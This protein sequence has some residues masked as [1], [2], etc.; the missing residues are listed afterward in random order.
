MKSG[1]R[2][3]VLDVHN[4]VLNWQE[5]QWVVLFLSHSL[6]YSE[7]K[8][9]RLQR[10]AHVELTARARLAKYGGVVRMKQ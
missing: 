7:M 5:V 3:F 10:F 9:Y 8:V 4:P 2:F 6:E 1:Y